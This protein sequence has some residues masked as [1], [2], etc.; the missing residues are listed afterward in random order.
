MNITQQQGAIMLGK[1][2][3]IYFH[4]SHK[5]EH[6]IQLQKEP[7]IMRIMNYHLMGTFVLIWHLQQVYHLLCASCME[8]YIEVAP[9]VKA[10]MRNRLVPR[11]NHFNCELLMPR[12]TRPIRFWKD[13]HKCVGIQAAVSFR[14][15]GD[16]AVLVAGI[17]HLH[18]W[19]RDGGCVFQEK[20][21]IP[22]S[23]CHSPISSFFNIPPIFSCVKK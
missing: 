22:F 5:M 10:C 2:L 18:Q 4:F 14:L 8:V 13:V 3:D 20:N 21:F 7:S 12:Y 15:I 9:W 1:N 23:E 11:D 16:G 19:D 17:Q 6:S